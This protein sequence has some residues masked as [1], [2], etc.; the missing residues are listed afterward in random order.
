MKKKKIE[1]FMKK[2]NPIK[3]EAVKPVD[4]LKPVSQK[5]SKP[6]NQQ[7][8]KMVE[9]TGEATDQNQKR[10]VKYT[11]YLPDE[12]ITKIKLRAVLEKKKAYQIIIQALEKFLE[13]KQ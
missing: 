4:L 6:E 7:D 9:Q 13:G 3:R 2:R 11:T 12:L 1:E 10:L 8:V 5:T